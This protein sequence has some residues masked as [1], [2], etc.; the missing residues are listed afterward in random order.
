MTKGQK[1]SLDYFWKN[2]RDIERYAE[3]E[4]ILPTLE[5]FYPEILKTWNEYKAIDKTMTAL[6]ENLNE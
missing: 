6:I 2:Y 3:Y 1:E 5:Q 4:D